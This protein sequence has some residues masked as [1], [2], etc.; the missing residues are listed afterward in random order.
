MEK[1]KLLLQNDC[2]QDVIINITSGGSWM[3]KEK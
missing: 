2:A 1:Q 3:N